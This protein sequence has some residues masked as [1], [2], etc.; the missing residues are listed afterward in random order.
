MSAKQ[1]I[2]TTY[3]TWSPSY[4]EMWIIASMFSILEIRSKILIGTYFR[5]NIWLREKIDFL[6]G[7]VLR[8]KWHSHPRC[9]YTIIGILLWAVLMQS[10]SRQNTLNKWISCHIFVFFPFFDPIDKKLTFVT[11]L[12]LISL[13]LAEVNIYKSYFMQC[14]FHTFKT[15]FIKFA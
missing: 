8:R 6:Y 1:P 5:V 11:I 10:I 2:G 12:I 7:D 13:P 9:R 4:G 15:S 3:F 14:T